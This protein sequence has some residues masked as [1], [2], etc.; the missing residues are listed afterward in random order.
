MSDEPASLTITRLAMRVAALSRREVFT[1]DWFEFDDLCTVIS[2]FEVPHSTFSPKMCALTWGI[3][4]A[5][6]P[7]NVLG[8]GVF[9][10]WPFAFL[11]GLAAH[12]GSPRELVAVDIEPEACMVCRRNL[13]Y[14]GFGD[15]LQ[16]TCADAIALH[17]EG[18]EIDLLFIDIDEPVSG[19]ARYSDILTHFRP[20]LA[21][22][23]LVLAHDVCVPRFQADFILWRKTVLDLGLRGPFDLPI[24]DC[25][26]SIAVA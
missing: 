23:A 26:V 12:V 15:Q 25:G 6:R 14:L 7:K 8:L 18:A 20:H 17:W 2:R 4:R 10:G 9:S 11:A 21:E 24:D 22:G 3:S 16:V 1:P 5:L 19:K 13:A